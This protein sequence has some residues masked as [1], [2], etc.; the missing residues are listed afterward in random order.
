VHLFPYTLRCRHLRSHRSPTL[1]NPPSHFPLF[2]RSSNP[3]LFV[4]NIW[5]PP[6]FKPEN[7]LDNATGKNQP[8]STSRQRLTHRPKPTPIPTTTYSNTLYHYQSYIAPGLQHHTKNPATA[9]QHIHH[10]S[11][12]QPKWWRHQ[13]HLN[14]WRQSAPQCQPSTTTSATIGQSK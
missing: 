10:H 4:S 7:N 6:C 8:T 5:R 13:P 11:R 1:S 14:Q 12:N 3:R 2:L 9:G